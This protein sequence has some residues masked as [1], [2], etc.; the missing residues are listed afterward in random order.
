MN[1]IE[2]KVPPETNSL[3]YSIDTT[4][5][6]DDITTLKEKICEVE[7][8]H[9]LDHLKLELIMQKNNSA[10]QVPSLEAD[11]TALEIMKLKEVMVFGLYRFVYLYNNWL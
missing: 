11:S 6:T 3:S 7:M 1:F 8:S 4:A 5:I 10:S 2:N 9:K